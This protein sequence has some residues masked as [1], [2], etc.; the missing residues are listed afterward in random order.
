M[1]QHKDSAN[2]VPP[3]RLVCRV[4]LSLTVAVCAAAA[5]AFLFVGRW[6][7]I[8]DPLQKAQAIVVLSGGIPER[9]AEAARLYREGYASK[10]LLTHPAEPSEALEA[11]GISYT[12]EDFYS[13]QVLVHQGVPQDAIEVVAP[14]IRNT[15]DEISAISKAMSAP[16]AATVIVVTSKPHT[17]RV[18]LLSRRLEP[19]RIRVLVRAADDPFNPRRWWATSSDALDV[20]REVL[21]I[22]NAWAGFPLHPSN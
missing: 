4:L 11:L 6:L 22:L 5:V 1:P 14:P 18:R 13:I 21:G 9:A 20:V 17:R 16:T 2:T 10:I 3:C 8:E 15:A 12:A 7:V 19:A